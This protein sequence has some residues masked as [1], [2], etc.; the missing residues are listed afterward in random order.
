MCSWG[1]NQPLIVEVFVS[2]D[3]NCR[4]INEVKRS[5]SPS[6]LILSSPRSSQAGG[7]YSEAWKQTELNKYSAIHSLHRH[8]VFQILTLVFSSPLLIEIPSVHTLLLLSS[9]VSSLRERKSGLVVCML[10][11]EI[12]VQFP[13]LLQTSTGTLNK[14]LPLSAYVYTGP[15]RTQCVP[16]KYSHISINTFQ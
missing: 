16:L 13:L 1:N 3:F 8:W 5:L 15:F 12:Q 6:S 2:K 10:T 9:C 11:W 7:C 4:E 14:S